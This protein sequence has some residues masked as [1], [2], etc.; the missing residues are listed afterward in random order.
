MPKLV[1][2]VT[3]VLRPG[4]HK[5]GTI[6]EGILEAGPDLPFPDRVEIEFGGD[7]HE[8]CFVFRRTREGQFC[9]DTW[10]EDLEGALQQAHFEYGLARADFLEVDPE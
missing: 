2:R 10:H 3:Q 6:R 1:A 4:I 7:I 5:I 9:G 8:P